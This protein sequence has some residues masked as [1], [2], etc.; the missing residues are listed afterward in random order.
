[1]TLAL[2]QSAA[3]SIA[4]CSIVNPGQILKNVEVVSVKFVLEESARSKE[5]LRYW[6]SFRRQLSLKGL[7]WLASAWESVEI[8][9]ILICDDFLL[10]PSKAV[11]IGVGLQDVETIV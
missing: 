11:C 4:F 3:A 8:V 9:K 7:L 6:I 10:T 1:M 5:E 2:L